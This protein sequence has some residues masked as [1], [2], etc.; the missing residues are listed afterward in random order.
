MNTQ[1]VPG[2][3]LLTMA[4]PSERAGLMEQPGGQHGEQPGSQHESAQ[5]RTAAAGSRHEQGSAELQ[6]MRAARAM[7]TPVLQGTGWLASWPQANAQAAMV[8]PSKQPSWGH[9]PSMGSI[10]AW[11]Q[12]TAKP[13]ASGAWARDLRQ[14]RLREEQHAQGEQRLAA[15]RH[16]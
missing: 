11:P 14:S 5:P 16:S 6:D 7:L 15:A 2:Q 10:T 4:G 8:C 3:V 12:K 9:A 13:M 1:K